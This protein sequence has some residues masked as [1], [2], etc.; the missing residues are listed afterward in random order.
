VISRWLGSRRSFLAL[1]SAVPF[2]GCD[3]REEAAAAPNAA[4]TFVGTVNGTDIRV[5][6]VAKGGVA[7]AFFCGGPASLRDTAWLRGEAR[8]GALE[9]SVAPARARGSFDGARL[10]GAFEPGDGRSLAFAAS[11]VPDDGIAGLYE[12]SDGSGRAAVIVFDPE[13]LQ[14][15]FIRAVDGSVLQIIPIREGPLLLEDAA[16]S[17][18]VEARVQRVYSI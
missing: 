3:D 1:A 9:C 5:G 10:S 6:V 16:L 14:G 17:V 8:A 18:R 2:V 13:H 15:A 7:I 12:L 4:G 11:A